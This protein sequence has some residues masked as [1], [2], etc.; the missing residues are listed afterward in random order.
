L[1]RKITTEGEIL[2][3]YLKIVFWRP[4]RFVPDT[5]SGRNYA[6]RP[7]DLYNKDWR[8]ADLIKHTISYIWSDVAQRHRRIGVV[9][10]EI[11]VRNERKRE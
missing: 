7:A 5:G 2:A 6:R 8:D 4:K 11:L 9:A 1:D 3:G 10:A